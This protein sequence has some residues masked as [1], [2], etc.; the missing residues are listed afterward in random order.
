LVCVLSVYCG[1]GWGAKCRVEM[2]ATNCPINAYDSI[3]FTFI[4]RMELT[5]K[6]AML[7]A[8]NAVQTASFVHV[9]ESAKIHH[10]IFEVQVAEKV[11]YLSIDFGALHF[12][13]F[14]YSKFFSWPAGAS[15]K[16]LNLLMECKDGRNNVQAKVE[17]L[18]SESKEI[19]PGKDDA[20]E[21]WMKNSVLEIVHPTAHSETK[22]EDKR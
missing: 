12:S 2:T 19:T 3:K 8:Y 22:E 16:R 21:T 4:E 5:E 18:D 6:G 15:P 1:H 14:P 17:I 7:P 11:R 13:P 20:I 9:G 10:S